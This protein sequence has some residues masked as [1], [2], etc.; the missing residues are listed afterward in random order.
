MRQQ[1]G[2]CHP[3]QSSS[4]TEGKAHSKNAAGV[5]FVVN[6]T[7]IIGIGL[8][9]LGNVSREEAASKSSGSSQVNDPAP[10]ATYAARAQVSNAC[11]YVL[12]IVTRAI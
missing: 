2:L 1:Q 7:K 11:F 3:S 10:G 9:K 12:P 4:R 5:T 6:A 8:A